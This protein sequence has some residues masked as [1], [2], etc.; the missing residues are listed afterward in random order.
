M[1]GN[2]VQRQVIN[3]QS[4][5]AGFIIQYDLAPGLYIIQL[6]QGDVTRSVR[7]VVR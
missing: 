6:S 5:D 2:E 3:R 1:I 7:W 4:M